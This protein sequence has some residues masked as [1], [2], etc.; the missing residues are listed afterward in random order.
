MADDE[1][2]LEQ[3][4]QERSASTDAIVRSA[5]RK[6]L[7]VAGPGTGKSFTFRKAL[8]EAI[9]A[10]G[11]GRGLAL[12]FIRNLVADLTKDLGDLADVFT[13]HGYCKHLMHQHNVGGLQAGAYYPPLIELAIEDVLLLEGRALKERDITEHLH[14]LDTADGVIDTVLA[15]ADYYNAVSHTDLVYRVLRHF[16]EKPETIPTYP[17][18]VVD[19]FQDFSLLETTFIALLASKNSVL[20]AGDDDQALYT[21]LKHASPAFIRDLAAGDEYEL[22]ELPYCSRCTH[23]VVAA[24]NDVLAKAVEGGHLA[25]RLAKQFQ[26]FL[27]DKK[28]DSDANPKII[29]VECS[30][31]NTEYMGQY[32]AQQ[33]A[34]IPAEDIARSRDKHYPT[35]LVIGP[36][37]F[38]GRAFAVV[39]RRSPNARMKKREQPAI[40][41]LDGYR[42]L[43]ADARSRLGWRIV[44]A[45]SPFDGWQAVL[46][47]VLQAESEIA[48]HL[49]NAYADEHLALARIVADL[50][51]SGVLTPESEARL[52]EAADR[53]IDDVSA[54]LAVADPDEIEVDEPA[55][56]ETEPDILF[57]S[58]VGSKG[59]SAEHVF[60]VGLNN[61]HFPR[62]PKAITDDEICSLLVAL[63]RTRRRCHVISCKW[64]GK[65]FLRESVFLDWIRP[66]LEKVSV[67]KSYDFSP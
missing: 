32:I 57:T 3:M 39:Q 62:K 42:R 35:A 49:P 27:P 64:F 33:I 36:N 38:L 48:D 55:D 13:F 17:L 46:K 18:I 12:T 41:I 44:I 51:E 4:R 34:L 50:L 9:L 59:L 20:V 53:S 40:D 30:S 26:C 56:A 31:G 16:E 60:I 11:G 5:A 43:A 2:R 6:R 21:N 66:H 15:R 28:A 45:C 67:N 1:Q 8:A 58:L 19:E 25:G 29:H 52:C 61:S 37:P 22:F 23:A 14:N 54:F 47:Q 24:V 10:A 63:S 7:I 65:G